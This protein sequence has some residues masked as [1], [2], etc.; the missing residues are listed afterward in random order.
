MVLMLRTLLADRFKL[1]MHME[2]KELPIYALVVARADGKLGPRLH[3]S[4]IDCQALM[5]A[6][7]G[8][9]PP[10]LRRPATGRPAACGAA[11]RR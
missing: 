5:A 1:A 8:G 10:V 3:P 7:R 4:S 11:P 9:P 6:R 2:T